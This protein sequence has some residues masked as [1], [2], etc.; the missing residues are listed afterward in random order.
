MINPPTVWPLN[1][2]CSGFGW[3]INSSLQKASFIGRRRWWNV[4]GYHWLRVVRSAYMR[5]HFHS[6]SSKK[7]VSDVMCSPF[8]LNQVVIVSIQYIVGPLPRLPFSK[9]IYFVPIAGIHCP[10]QSAATA[11]AAAT[12][13]TQNPANPDCSAA[14]ARAPV[15][16]Q[17]SEGITADTVA[18]QRGGVRPSGVSVMEAT[19][20]GQLRILRASYCRAPSRGSCAEKRPR[21][22]LTQDIINSWWYNWP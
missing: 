14:E 8:I 18:V 5:V 1:I 6:F 3:W 9:Y 16:V 13:T 15:P 20:Q 17:P 19:S 12:A 22:C 21:S 10:L 11:A 7:V 4:K 2:I